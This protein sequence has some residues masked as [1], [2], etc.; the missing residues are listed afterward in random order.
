MSTRLEDPVVTSA[1]R[2]A[3]AVL[4]IWLAAMIYTVGYCWMFG[5]GRDPSDLK[6]ILGFPDWVLWGVVAPWGVC[7]LVSGWFAFGY[8]TDE[9]LGA[10]QEEADEEPESHA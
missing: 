2:E 9:D 3:L 10:E 8:M 5:Y 1:R 4:V 6:L 7:A